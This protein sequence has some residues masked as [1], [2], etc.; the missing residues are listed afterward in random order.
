MPTKFY[1]DDKEFAYVDDIGNNLAPNYDT[2]ASYVAGDVVFYE[3]QLYVCNASTTGSWDSTK[4][5]EGSV[6]SIILGLIN[7]GV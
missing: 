5:D 2:T 4:W 3:G 1:Y 7:T 6:A